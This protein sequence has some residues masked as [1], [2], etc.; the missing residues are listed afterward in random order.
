MDRIEA[1]ARAAR[2]LVQGAIAAGGVAA[3]L[4]L[5]TALAGGEFQPRIVIVA[6]VTAFIT[7]AVSYLYNSI[8]P[9]LGI[10][11]N[12]RIEALVRALRTLLAGAISTALLAAWETMYSAA[13]AGTFSPWVLGT[14]AASAGVTAFVA[15]VHNLLRPR[16]PVRPPATL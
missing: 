16:D 12:P 2:S 5:Q 7:A 3:W 6:V 10:A 4:A 1:L 15:F 8:A 9:R 11:G 14:A 13:Q